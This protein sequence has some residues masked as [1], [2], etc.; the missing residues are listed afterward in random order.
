MSATTLYNYEKQFLSEALGQLK[1]YL[2]SNEIF[3]QLNLRSLHD[4]PPYPQL[5]LGN[6]L[7]SRA[8]LTGL[9][10]SG[11]LSTEQRTDL[12]SLETLIGELEQE[13]RSAWEKKAEREYQAR[14]TQW[15]RFL[16]DMGDS[17]ERHG[18]YFATEVRVRAILSLIEGDL[19]ASAAALKSHLARQDQR[20]VRMTS[21]ADFVWDTE[22]QGA[23]PKGSYW[24]LWVKVK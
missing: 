24:F 14:L 6:F 12:K 4:A 1:D 16:D 13:W 11:Q 7:L 22:V 17:P 2:L 9:E 21:K 23:F 18:A 20:L 19:P 15:E 10:L 3:W 5:T 8:K